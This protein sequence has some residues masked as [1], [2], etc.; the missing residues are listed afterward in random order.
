MVSSSVLTASDVK[1]SDISLKDVNN[2]GFVDVVDSENGI[3]WNQGNN[4]YNSNE[5]ILTDYELT[6]DGFGSYYPHQDPV[7]ATSLNQKPT[8]FV[9]NHIHIDSERG[10]IANIYNMSTTFYEK[11]NDGTYLPTRA[12]NPHMDFNLFLHLHPISENRLE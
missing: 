11:N 8:F 12:I 3:F 10:H 1:S 4:Q 6:K 5:M 7:N 9:F 2:D